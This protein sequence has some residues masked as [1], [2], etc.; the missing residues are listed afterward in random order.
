MLGLCKELESPD[1]SPSMFFLKKESRG[2]SYG[3]R[4]EKKQPSGNEVGFFD[5]DR[6]VLGRGIS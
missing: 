6:A 3:S 4:R 2:R 1:K 5:H